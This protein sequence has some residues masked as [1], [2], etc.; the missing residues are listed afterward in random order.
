MPVST[1]NRGRW[2]VAITALV[3]ACAAGAAD[4]A[5]ILRVA[6]PD[7]ETLDPQQYADNPSYQVVVAIFEP[8]YEWDYLA[9]PPRLTPLT[10]AAPVDIT[11]NGLTWTMRVRPGILFTDDAAFN[12][13]PRELIAQ[14]YVYSYK[15]WLDPNGRRGGAP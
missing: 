2:L 12:G 15:R 1:V 9:S 6:S 7:I 13:K 8:L 11:D 14:D 3:L 10:A 4:P 5:K